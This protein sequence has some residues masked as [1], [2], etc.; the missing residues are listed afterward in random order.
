MTATGHH[1]EAAQRM[2][3]LREW[4]SNSGY[5]QRP[6]VLHRDFDNEE[7]CIELTS[8][9]RH[10]LVDFPGRFER[11]VE[12][13]SGDG[14]YLDYLNCERLPLAI[15]GS[16]IESP[17]LAWARRQFPHIPF[18][19]GDIIQIAGRHAR[20]GTVFLAI[21]VLGNI[22]PS[23]LGTFLSSIARCSCAVVFCAGVLPLESTEEF[24]LRPG[25]G[26]NHNF[27]LLIRRHD[28]KFLRY[29]MRYTTNAEGRATLTAT[30]ISK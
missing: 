25:L 14:R 26:Y 15:L 6:D 4:S 20:P 1:D 29:L 24:I 9:L 12:I 17:R 16:D 21:D 27:G 23:D 10:L 13:G 5:S 28:L 18:E 3:I 8:Q 11:L 19:A 2:E 22:V 7:V 30:V